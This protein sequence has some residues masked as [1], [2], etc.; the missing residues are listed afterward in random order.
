MTRTKT[1]PRARRALGAVLRGRRA[2]RAR[3]AALRGVR[4]FLHPVRARCSRC[5]DARVAWAEA[6]GRGR[7]SGAT[8]ALHRSYLPEHEGLLPLTLVWVE[9][10]EGVRFASRLARGEA[11]DVRT[12]DRVA[13]VFERLP[14]GTPVPVFN[15]AA[16]NAT[17]RASAVAG[18]R[19][20]RIRRRARPRAA[21][22]RGAHA[23]VRVGARVPRRRIELHGRPRARP[24]GGGGGAAQPRARAGT[25]ARLAAQTAHSSA[26]SPATGVTLQPGSGA[27]RSQT[28]K[29]TRAACEDRWRARQPITRPA[30]VRQ[31]SSSARSRGSA[32][33]LT[34]KRPSSVSARARRARRSRERRRDRRGRVAEREP[35]VRHSR[36]AIERAL[37]RGREVDARPRLLQRAR[38]ERDLVEL[39]A[40]AAVLD[41]GVGPELLAER[42][43]LGQCGAV[44]VGEPDLDPPAGAPVERGDLA[45]RHRAGAGPRA[46]RPRVRPELATWPRRAPEATRAHS[47]SS[48][49][50]A[51]ATRSRAL[52]PRA[53]ARGGSPASGVREARRRA[54]RTSRHSLTATPILPVLRWLCTTL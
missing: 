25:S 46:R 30:G 13:V 14:D 48:S 22:G 33:A 15:A 52:R 50:R 5:G 7:G 53:R 41:A 20:T 36:R 39:E 6:S 11:A 18:G 47:R 38:L 24:A 4:T 31:A 1:R 26:L 37:G 42:D 23:A 19:A 12:G 35:A 44:A 32:R 8:G 28:R 40:G 17:L 3:A 2:R 21:V 45:R 54:R 29:I 27:M 51:R 49:R 9:L 34:W 43:R 16:A 10:D